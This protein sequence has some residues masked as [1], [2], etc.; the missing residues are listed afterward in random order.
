MIEVLLGHIQR[1]DMYINEAI[2]MSGLRRSELD[3]QNLPSVLER[4]QLANPKFNPVVKIGKQ[5]ISW[6]RYLAQSVRICFPDLDENTAGF[7]RLLFAQLVLNE[8]IIPL[9]GTRATIPQ[10]HGLQIQEQ[11]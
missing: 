6:W 2:R 8:I 7:N 5:K 1:L 4:T 11:P 10:E 3:M 9:H